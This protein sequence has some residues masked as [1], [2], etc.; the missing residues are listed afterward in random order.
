MSATHDGALYF[1]LLSYVRPY[2]KA[3]GLAVLGM[4]AAAA[5][6]PLFPALMKPLLDGG[7][8][9]GKQ[10]LLPPMAFAAAL[11]AIFVVRGILSFVSSYFLAWVANRVVLD[12]RAA[13]F[14]RLVMKNRFERAVNEQLMRQPSLEGR[15]QSP[16]RRHRRARARDDASCATPHSKP[17][18]R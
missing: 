7:F 9:A 14:A 11:V 17:A 1:R 5:T 13:M 3:F 12:L 18:Y 4:V 15:R 16:C 8:G 10:P 2:S 6:E